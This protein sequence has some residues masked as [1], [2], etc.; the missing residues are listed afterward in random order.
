MADTIS[1]IGAVG[2]LANI[3]DA[4]NKA[5]G[6]ICEL[7]NQW[8]EAD[9][10]FLSLTAQLTA[11]QAALRKLKEWVDSDIGDAHHQLVMDLDASIRCCGMLLAKIDSLLSELQRYREH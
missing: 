3:I 9:L 5:I 1:I 6:T 11:L 2:A 8:K 10:A 7:R 4:V